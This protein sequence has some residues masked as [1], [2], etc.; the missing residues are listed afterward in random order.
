MK[1]IAKKTPLELYHGVVPWAAHGALTWGSFAM[2]SMNVSPLIA[3]ISFYV[4]YPLQT[5][6][7]RM[8]S[9]AGREF[10]QH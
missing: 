1:E 3:P 4:F 8:A 2:L 5:I 6:W 10:K 7:V 9:E